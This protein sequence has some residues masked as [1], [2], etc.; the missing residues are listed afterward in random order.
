MKKQFV[1]ILLIVAIM[2]IFAVWAS[3]ANCGGTNVCNCGDTLNESRTL[4]ASDNLTGCSGNGLTISTDDLVF[5]C[6]NNIISGD[7]SGFD[8][9]VGISSANNVTV[10]NCNIS[11]FAGWAVLVDGDN[12]TLDN[13]NFINNYIGAATIH[14]GNNFTNNY[15]YNDVLSTVRGIYLN[16]GANNNSLINNTIY[17]YLYGIHLGGG[18]NNNLL[19]ENNLYNNTYGIYMTASSNVNT[20]YHNNIYDSNTNEVYSD[21]AINLSYSN[22]GNYWGRTSCPVFIAGTD[23]NAVNVIDSYPYKLLDGWD[24]ESPADCSPQVSLTSP[25]NDT[26]ATSDQ[27]DFVFTPTSQINTTLS[28]ELFINDTSRGTNTTSANGTATTITASTALADGSYVWY[29]NCTDFD[30]TVQSQIWTLKVDEAAPTV[31]PSSPT[32][33]EYTNNNTVTYTP[34]DVNLNTCAWYAI[35]TSNASDISTGAASANNGVLNSQALTLTDG[36]FDWYINCTDGSGN[37]GLSATRTINYDT[38]AP[39]ISAT[40]AGSI[41]SSGATITW[42]T[43]ENANSRVD[44]GKNTSLG[45]TSSNAAYTTSH[46][47]SLSSLSASTLY[48]Y[49]VTSCDQAGNCQ[50]DGGYTFTTSAPYQP[51]SRSGGGRAPTLG[52]TGKRYTIGQEPFKV[53]L[54]AGDKITFLVDGAQHTAQIYSFG[55]SYVILSVASTV[56]KVRVDLNQ[57]TKIDVDK[58]SIYDL[59][60]TLN[61]INGGKSA[62]ITFQSLSEAITPAILE[63]PAEVPAE[64]VQPEVAEEKQEMVQVIT[65]EEKKV[66]YIL[67]VSLAGVALISILI[68]VSYYRNR[69]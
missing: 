3:A 49:N 54:Y 7:D 44:Y 48:Y 10:K 40:A 24:S 5:D 38:T 46:S 22:E 12:N 13:N 1:L 68:I 6:D 56:E 9:G 51:P 53:I 59:A 67:L 50:T 8:W 39:T 36:S 64:E 19:R 37:V 20:I 42:T 27:P 16:N 43:D 52:F 63:A 11:D 62:D 18:S 32:D 35:N 47:I 61:K 65:P 45:S 15:I 23:S 60:A 17:N 25:G 26:W 57:T 58:D 41:T 33:N 69:K 55:D 4:N 2:S 31:T 28:C 14:S 29:I 21:A 66:N 30:S 34:S